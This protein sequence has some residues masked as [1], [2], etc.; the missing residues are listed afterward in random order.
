MESFYP[1]T[2]EDW[3]ALRHRYVS[4]TDSPALFGASPYLTAFELATVKQEE[5][6]VDSEAGERATWGLRLQ[7]AI[8]RGF[9]EDQGLK[10]R[11][12]NAFI[13]GDTRMGA[14]FDFEIIGDTG[15]NPPDGNPNYK[16][17][18]EQMGPG[19]LEVKNVDSLIFRDNWTE[20]E[21]PSHIEI[22]VQ[23]QLHCAN[24]EWSAISVMV[25][26]NRI[27]PYIRIRDK[28]VG[29]AIEGKVVD[30]WDKLGKGILP[31]VK[32]PEDVGIIRKLYRHSS[33]GKVMDAQADPALRE[34]VMGL[35]GAY[36]EYAAG[37]K[38]MKE[39]RESAAAELLMLIGDSERVLVEGFNV[40]AGTVKSTVIESYTRE[41]YR[42]LRITEKKVPAPPKGFR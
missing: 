38:A 25:G 3:L 39:R 42:N 6:P 37:E 11:A 34:K 8:A 26:G 4:S 9:G 13:G 20:D 36:R 2:R 27:V 30:F 5:K 21:M 32:L 31:P 12:L 23:H 22:Q 41:A 28:P 24:R 33:E 1:K 10:V 18:Y 15:T 16:R 7:R 29:E 19:I 35:C 40:S 17:L 14:S